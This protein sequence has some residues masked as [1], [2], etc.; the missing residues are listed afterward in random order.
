MKK[1]LA[2][3]VSAA[4]MLSMSACGADTS[5]TTSNDAGGI[6][7]GL[8]EIGEKVGDLLGIEPKEEKV[9][10]NPLFKEGLLAVKVDG[11]WGYIDES[12]EFVIEPQFLNAENFQSNGLA[13]VSAEWN[14]ENG[15][16]QEL[17]GVIDKNGNYVIEPQFW[18][19]ENFQSNGLAVVGGHCVKNGEDYLGLGVI[20]K[21]GNYVIMPEYDI[22]EK[23]NANGVAK[24]ATNKRLD[25]YRAYIY[26]WGF[27]N[28][29]GEIILEP[30]HHEIGNF[31]CGWAKVNDFPYGDCCNYIDKDGNFLIDYTNTKFG[32]DFLTE[33]NDFCSN[34]LARVR[35]GDGYVMGFIDTNADCPIEIKYFDLGNF[36]DGDLTYACIFGEKYGFIDKKGNYIIE[37]QFDKAE[38]F[39][40]NGYAKVNIG[41]EFDIVDGILAEGK[42][43]LIDKSGNYVVQPIYDEITEVKCDVAIVKSGDKCGF[44]NFKKNI[45]IEPQ[46][47]YVSF[48]SDRYIR[49]T[50]LS[51]DT[52]YMDFNGNIDSNAEN[53][54]C[55]GDTYLGFIDSDGNA[56]I[57]KK[58]LENIDFS[59]GVKVIY[60]YG[61]SGIIDINGNAIILRDVYIES[62][63]NVNGIALVSE[64]DSEGRGIYGY[65]KTNGE[66]FIEPQY[67]DASQFFDD[68]YAFVKKNDKYEIINKNGENVFDKQ[69][70]M[71]CS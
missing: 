45:I 9:L 46:Y 10:K 54:I 37:P 5:G 35:V 63:F 25:E 43:G 57:D 23:F 68:N 36:A 21:N 7:A 31:N 24:I 22:I 49:C 33:V 65:I 41:Y 60:R 50:T 55:I 52:V 18:K 16:T 71:I 1:H 3:I 15:D 70:E 14:D 28:E 62:E 53:S 66:Y 34:G 39:D 12:G 11:K 69:F 47:D 29:N 59:N 4:L 2:L 67:R 8:G 6:S 13:I 42:W 61:G 48:Q 64:I 17:Y 51:S 20:D 27:I 58:C 32:Y 40:Y 26:D 44:I 19:A 30:I 56:Q 38:D